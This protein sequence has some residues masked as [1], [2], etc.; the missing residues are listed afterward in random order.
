MSIVY[1]QMF[2]IDVLSIGVSCVWSYVGA[3]VYGLG[4]YGILQNFT[5]YINMRGANT[6]QRGTL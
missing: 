3:L 2:V 6:A 5:I 4:V 1:V